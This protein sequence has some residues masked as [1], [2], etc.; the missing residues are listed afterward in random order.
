MSSVEK[1]FGRDNYSFPYPS[2]GLSQ[3]DALQDDLEASQ[4]TSFL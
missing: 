2:W 4:A 1:L 3:K